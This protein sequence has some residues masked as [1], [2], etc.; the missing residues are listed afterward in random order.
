[1]V[2]IVAAEME[3]KDSDPQVA[4]LL[5][6]AAGLGLPPL[7]AQTWTGGDPCNN[8]M[9]V[10]CDHNQAVVLVQLSLYSMS[11]TISPVISNLKGLKVLILSRSWCSWPCRLSYPD[12]RTLSSMDVAFVSSSA[13]SIEAPVV[14][15]FGVLVRRNTICVSDNSISIGS[16]FQC[17]SRTLLLFHRRRLP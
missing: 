4:T 10:T 12:G 3:S 15:P 11:G 8:W 17:T 1:M 5:Q 6:M 16:F 7:V 9:G 14:G 13:R 2:V